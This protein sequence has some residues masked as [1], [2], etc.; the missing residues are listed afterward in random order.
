MISTKSIEI[1]NLISFSKNFYNS[2]KFSIFEKLV[3]TKGFLIANLKIDFDENGNVK[4]N[5]NAKGYVNNTQL[6]FLNDFEIDKLNFVFNIEKK[7]FKLEDINFSL[8]EIDFVS[9]KIDIKKNDEEYF[10]KGVLSNSI[11]ELSSR[12]L[13]L[14]NFFSNLKLNK[15]R[16]SSTTNFLLILEKI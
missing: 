10:I 9:K 16:F 11:V 4:D 12:N 8:N 15:I 13:K 14:L 7:K 3:K 6:N 5:Y 1:N 2:P